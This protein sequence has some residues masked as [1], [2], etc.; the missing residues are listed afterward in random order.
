[1]RSDSTIKELTYHT[2]TDVRI[3]IAS[4]EATVPKPCLLMMVMHLGPEV[5]EV[6]GLYLTRVLCEAFDTDANNTLDIIGALEELAKQNVSTY[7]DAS[8][9]SDDIATVALRSEGVEAARDTPAEVF[10][11]VFVSSLNLLITWR[12]DAT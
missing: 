7:Q 1:M 6:D 11:G 3:G 2:E 12:D 5:I 9:T 4:E 10:A 8:F